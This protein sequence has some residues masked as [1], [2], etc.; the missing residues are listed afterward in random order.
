MFT[1]SITRSYQ[2]CFGQSTKPGL[3]THVLLPVSC[4]AEEAASPFY[5]WDKAER[6]G[7]TCARPCGPLGETW[8]QSPRLLFAQPLHICSCQVAAKHSLSRVL[9]PPTSLEGCCASLEAAEASPHFDSRSLG[10]FRV[11]PDVIRATAIWVCF[12]QRV[13]CLLYKSLLNLLQ[14]CFCCLCSAFLALRHRRS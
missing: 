5:R 6:G 1:C 12:C 4:P 7:V 9:G 13:F 14:Y 2:A 11:N 10:S 3:C 8:Y